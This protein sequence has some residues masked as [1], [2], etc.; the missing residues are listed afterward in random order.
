MLDYYVHLSRKG[1]DFQKEVE[2]LNKRELNERELHELN[3]MNKQD[4]L[5]LMNFIGLKVYEGTPVIACEEAELKLAYM[6]WR[7]EAISERKL[8]V[9]RFHRKIKSWKRTCFNYFFMKGMY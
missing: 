3:E 8:I 1:K 2:N 9:R 4:L 7:S 6:V 5:E